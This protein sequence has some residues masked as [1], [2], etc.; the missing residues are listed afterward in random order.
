MNKF[1]K[2]STTKIR[3]SDDERDNDDEASDNEERRG[4]R[5]QV[6]EGSVAASE[7]DYLLSMPIWSLTLERIEDLEAKMNTKKEEHD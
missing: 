7:Y 4:P 2:K 3:D 6:D 5:E 1:V